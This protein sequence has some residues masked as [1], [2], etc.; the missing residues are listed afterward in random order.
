MLSLESTA[1]RMSRIAKSEL[2]FDRYDSPDELV[3]KIDAVKIDEIN[4][5]CAELL[6]PDHLTLAAIGPW[7]PD[8]A[9]NEATPVPVE[10][11]AGRSGDIES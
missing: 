8:D 6:N 1:G 5:L 4:S 7:S 9:N 10:A 2:F 3:A 11:T